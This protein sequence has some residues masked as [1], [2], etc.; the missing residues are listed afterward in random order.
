MT[1]Q[2]NLITRR[3]G[4]FAD[5]QPLSQKQ[6]KV[7]D[8]FFYT[9]L[10]GTFVAML[11]IILYYVYAFAAKA[12]G[13]DAFDW[14]LGIFSD[15]VYIMNVSLEESPY[16]VEDSSYPPLAIAVLYPFA[17]ICKGVFARY[18]AQELT[19]D[20]LTSRV[21]LHGEF[22]ISMV[23]FF[24]LCSAAVIL[25]LIKVYK[26][27]P[28]ASL[29]VGLIIL[30]C[31]PFIYAVMR[32]NTIYFAMIFLLVFLLLY[33]NESAV[34]REVGYIALVL[35][36]LIKIYPLF[37]GVFL[38][39][40]KKLFASFRIAVYTVALFFLSFF[41]FEGGMLH[42]EPFIENLGGFAGNEERLLM[43]NNLSL[44]HLLYCI[45]Y[46]F[47]LSD[48]VFDVINLCMLALIFLFTT[49]CAV[50]TRSELSR[51]VIAAA[52]VVLIPSVSYF[53]VLIFMTLPFMCFIREYDSLPVIKQRLYSALFLVMLF[54]PLLLPKNFLLQSLAVIAMLTSEC[55]EV[56]REMGRKRIKTEN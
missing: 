13:G 49:V 3:R 24:V 32:G 37:F 48:G 30:T 46:P 53:Y 56:V 11:G 1:S 4:L 5:A 10:G 6:K 39:S 12:N 23:L 7:L 38:L 50:Y 52:V 27:P 29:K 9:V 43:G 15:F 16:I 42:L 8:I 35:A 17:L 40:K 47:S 44:T 26:L 33:N 51:Y 31:S 19:V 25:L 18:S 36:G 22:W 20:E 14:L 21:I 55:V 34:L 41:L 28:A 54:A 45:L 2:V